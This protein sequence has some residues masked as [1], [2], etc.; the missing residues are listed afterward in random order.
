MHQVLSDK[1][2]FNLVAAS[3]Q[4]E[5]LPLLKSNLDW[6]GQV[7]NLENQLLL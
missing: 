1:Y 3:K 4:S 7:H 2:T 6:L 5:K